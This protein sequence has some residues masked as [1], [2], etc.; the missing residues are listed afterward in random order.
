VAG[1][2]VTMVPVEQSEVTELSLLAPAS[3]ASQTPRRAR[4]LWSTVRVNDRGR[5]QAPVGAERLNS[6]R[7]G[8]CAV[9]ALKLCHLLC[10]CEQRDL[11]ERC[12]P[13][14]PSD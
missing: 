5:T 12:E 8:E 9:G 6:T 2:A 10:E 4:H 1:D 3:R 14:P 11:R 7:Y 13:A